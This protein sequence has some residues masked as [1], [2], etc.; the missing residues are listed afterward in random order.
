M[1]TDYTNVGYADDTYRYI[2]K[3]AGIKGMFAPYAENIQ[4]RTRILKII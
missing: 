2:L 3:L 1:W 4:R